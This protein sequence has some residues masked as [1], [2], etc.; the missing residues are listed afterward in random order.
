MATTRIFCF[1]FLSAFGALAHAGLMLDMDAGATDLTALEVGDTFT[2]NVNLNGLTGELSS[3]GGTIDVTSL[4]SV[5]GLSLTPGVIVPVSTDL[6]LSVFPGEVDAQFFAIDGPNITTNGV[7]FSF[8]LTASAVGT[9]TIAFVPFTPFA[10]D[11]NFSPI[12][13]IETNSIDFSVSSGGNVVPEPASFGCFALL[14]AI[15]SVSRRQRKCN[16]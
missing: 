6:I 10:D 3:L 7:F 5:D 9:G 12:F 11:E 15:G 2:V 8:E 1:I 13:D 16:S 14:L 4:L